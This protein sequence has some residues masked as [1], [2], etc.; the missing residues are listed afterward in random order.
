[1]S[2]MTLA[3]GMLA[4]LLAAGNAQAENSVKLENAEQARQALAAG[5]LVSVPDPP[6]F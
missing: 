4:A 6:R 1:M 2:R 5:L 3:T